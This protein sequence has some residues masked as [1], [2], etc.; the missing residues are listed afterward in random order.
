[1]YG[2]QDEAWLVMKKRKGKERGWLSVDSSTII[3]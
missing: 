2:I 1:M 3:P